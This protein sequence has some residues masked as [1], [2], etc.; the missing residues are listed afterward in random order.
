MSNATRHERIVP[1]KDQPGDQRPLFSRLDELERAVDS[2]SAQ[3][4]TLQERLSPVLIE[5]A[6]VP[7]RLE[8][9]RQAQCGFDALILT[10][11]ERIEDLSFQMARVIDRLA[12]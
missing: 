11:Q 6:E 4:A 5:E 2:I 9:H 12:L 8:P 10:S 3:F 7:G 1:L